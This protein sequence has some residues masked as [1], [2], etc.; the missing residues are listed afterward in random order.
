[1]SVF[2]VW[3][4]TAINDGGLLRASRVPLVWPAVIMWAWLGSELSS[5]HCTRSPNPATHANA[6]YLAGRNDAKCMVQFAATQTSMNIE[7]KNS[8]WS[9][10]G[11]LLGAVMIAAQAQ[12]GPED[13][14]WHEPVDTRLAESGANRAEILKALGEVSSEKREG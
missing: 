10:L 1:M 5:V 8:G 13:R 6:G 11:I 2:G 4:A 14:W 12:A 7:T 3:V 9:I